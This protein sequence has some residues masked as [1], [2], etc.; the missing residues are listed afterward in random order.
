[1]DSKRPREGIANIRRREVKKLFKGLGKKVYSDIEEGK[2]PEIIFPSRSVRNIVYDEGLKQYILGNTS[3]KRSTH[4]IKHIRPFTQLI[5][6]AFFVN[7]L[8]EQS[9]TSTLR[10]VFYSAQAYDVE[11]VDQA[12]SDEIITDL[13]AVLSRAREDFNVYPEERSAI[14][15]DLTIEYTVPGYEGKRLNLAS[16]PDGYLI[17]PSLSTADFVDTSAEMV[18][19]VEKGGLFTR[20]VEEKVHKRYKALVIDTAGQPP[21]STRYMLKR[22]NHEL[23]LPVYVLTD[24]DVYGEHIAMVIISGSANAAHLREL[25]VPSGKW[26]GVWGSDIVKYKL[27]SNSLTDLDIKRVHE[28]KR[29]PR[30]KGGVWQRELDVFLKIRKK[31]ELEAFAKYGLTT[32]TDKYLPE[33]L[34][35]AK[36]L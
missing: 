32:I 34:D 3:V 7:K 14:F 29:D 33:K 35:V 21:R 6:L 10:D 18:L 22:L 30:Y 28:L 16:H 27:P 11:F 1:M 9:K 2:F 26:I 12:E 4:N 5:W 25:T 8:V 13:E 31:S 15:G 20:F 19:A 24:G 23:G 36:S 17:G